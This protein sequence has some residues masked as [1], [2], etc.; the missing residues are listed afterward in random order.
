MR[1]APGSYA[2]LTVRQAELLSLLRHRETDGITPSYDE[3]M[4]ALGLSSKS[5]VSRLVAALQERGYI[6]RSYGLARSIKVRDFPIKT[7]VQRDD[8]DLAS[9]SS[10]LLLAEIRRRMIEMQV[11]A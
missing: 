1:R 11:D 9:V 4:S 6:D 3:M 10:L 2:G 7:S 5:A 8:V